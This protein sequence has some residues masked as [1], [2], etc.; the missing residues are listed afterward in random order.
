MYEGQALRLV[1]LQSWP[2][3]SGSGP[4]VTAAIEK[5][6]LRVSLEE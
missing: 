2:A 3:D 5:P 1:F 4:A 6:V